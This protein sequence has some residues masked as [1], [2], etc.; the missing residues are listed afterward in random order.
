IY[1]DGV[2][3]NSGTYTAG[4]DQSGA[5]VFIG[6]FKSNWGFINGTIDDVLILN[7]SLSPEQVKAL[8]QN[9][10][11]TIAYDETTKHESWHCSITPNDGQADG[12]TLN[13]TW[14]EIE[15]SVPTT[16]ILISP[17]NN[18]VLIGNI[19]TL[20]W[21]ATDPDGDAVTYYIYHSN[22]EPPSFLGSTSD[23]NIST[24]ATTD[25]QT[26]Y[27]YVIAGDDSGNSS[28]SETRQYRENTKPPQVTLSHP[29]NN[30]H[31]TDRTPTFN[32]T[33]V[34]D[35]DG[36]GVEYILNIT[37]TCVSS[38]CDI[39]D[40][41]YFESIS[42]NEYTLQEVLMNLWE[43]GDYEDYY[44][45][46]VKVW[47]GYEYGDV[48]DTFSLYIDSLVVLTV[49]NN[50]VDFGE[51]GNGNKTNTTDPAYDPLAIQNDGNC[52]LDVNLSATALWQSVSF[53]S[54]YYQYKIDEY[55]GEANSYNESASTITWTDVP[56]V[57]ETFIRFLNYSDAADSAEV[58]ILIEVP[59]DEP[60]G[61]KNSTII[62][63]GW[64][65]HE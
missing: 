30:N 22:S 54:S 3:K 28:A 46:T 55:P 24:G 13:S 21:T 58:D 33:E 57:N 53:P 38:E 5:N 8:Y 7:I 63:T 39:T 48:S 6:A 34:T 50:T 65:V 51:L 41:R 37:P 56:L 61:T 60:A 43:Q 12:T 10:T 18:S 42:G 52:F 11:Q 49:I 27:W 9:G 26:Y 62:F 23:T 44:S 59:L 40:S 14:I 36:D 25:G 47:D 20:N 45:W 64:Y 17:A 16:P 31:T 35:A 32:W 4:I 19:H 29:Q 2:E 15:E 1:V